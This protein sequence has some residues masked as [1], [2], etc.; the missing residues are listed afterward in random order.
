MSF[1]KRAFFLIVFKFILTSA[2]AQ[3]V[4][5]SVQVLQ[6]FSAQA[7]LYVYKGK[8]TQVVDS[9]WRAKP[10]KFSFHLNEDYKQGLYKLSVGNNL[11]FN[12]IVSDEPQIDISTVAY[13]PEDSLRFK[14]SKENQIFWKYQRKKKQH[15]QQTWLLKSLKE[16]YSH[17]DMFFS[18]IE[19]EI[20]TKDE[21]LASFANSIKKE[22]PDLLASTYIMVEQNPIA[23]D[24]FDEDTRKAYLL[25]TWWNDIDFKDTRL[26]YTPAFQSRVWGYME[27]YFNDEF[28]KEEQDKAFILGVNNL[29]ELEMHNQ[30]KRYVRE[31]LING[32]ADS[33]YEPV[34]EHIE[35]SGFGDLEPLREK[36]SFEGTDM[37]PNLKV[38]EKAYDFDVTLPNGDTKKLSEIESQY[39]LILFWSSWCPHCIETM[40]DFIDIYRRYKEHGLEVIAVSIDEE[41]D[42]WNRHVDELNLPW[43]N[44]REPLSRE[45]MLL[46][47]YNV[48]VTP[49]M[50][51]LS[52]DLTILSRPSNHRQLNVRLRRLTR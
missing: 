42:I 6:S 16:F 46:F 28:D 13:A 15:R 40:P 30:V 7:K 36:A 20:S 31:V 1:F 10:G 43:I 52:K 41:E 47:K 18:L 4:S 39:K 45:S 2:F 50:F 38:G 9:A 24:T 26:L 22:H 37:R 3:G 11:S 19:R 21:E 32:F 12:F 33:D 34:L 35:T 49:L 23:P 29:M 44:I 51:L 17:D 25:D 5:I 14:N 48:E 27:L 8:D